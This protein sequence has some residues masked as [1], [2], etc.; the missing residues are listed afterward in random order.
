MHLTVDLTNF[1]RQERESLLRHLQHEDHAAFTVAQVNQARA[2]QTLRNCMV[3]G[4]N[5]DGLGQL[6]SVIDVGMMNRLAALYGHR[7]V[8][9]DPDFKPWL[10]KKHD[11]FRVPDVRTKI[12][13]GWTP[14]KERGM[15]NA[16]CGTAAPSTL[17]S[18]LSTS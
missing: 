7:T 13:V 16:E 18:Q 8:H 3:P 12:S 14:E 17:N 15:R 2:A 6:K 10:L 1:S 9:S 11:E 4:S 5:R